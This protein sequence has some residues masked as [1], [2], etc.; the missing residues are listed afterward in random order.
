MTR[1]NTAQQSFMTLEAALSA[2]APRLVPGAREAV[3]VRRLSGG[4]SQEI[5][6]FR[7]GDRDLI[8]RRKPAGATGSGNAVGLNTEAAL[9]RAA[10][11]KG[12]PVPEVVHVCT[13]EDG[14]GE[15]YVMG[16]VEGE[17]L[18]ARIVRNEAFA[19]IRPKLAGQC[20]AVLA[21]IH[22]IDPAS[23]PPLTTSDALTELEKYEGVYR[24][25]GSERPIFEAAFRWLRDRAPKLE[26][27]TLLH[28][29]FRNGNIMF[30]PE[31]GV[32]AVLDWELAHLGDPAE[33]LAW[34]CVNS[35]RFG[36]LKPVGGFGEY[37][38]LLEGYEAAG[39]K[40]VPLERVLYWQTLGSLKWGCMCMTMYA[41]Y[42]SGADASVE[43]AMI[44]R[45]TSE[46]EIDLIALLE[47]AA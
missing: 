34:I 42:A 3:D 36:G 8:L 6:A 43:R 30:Q 10:A 24:T 37:A 20:G 47:R 18:G 46:T 31:A 17:T 35:W 45:R 41:S 39:G 25:V 21:Q 33:D 44:G 12:A 2:L 38:Q 32:A 28:G 9:I 7:V 11:A 26:K 27:P 1:G 14:I 5:W 22:T 13:E 16:K 29:D 15:A 23:V 40:P 19:A 4:A